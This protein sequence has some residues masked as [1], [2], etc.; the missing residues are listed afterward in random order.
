MSYSN[1]VSF[2]S[3]PNLVQPSVSFGIC[4]TIYTPILNSRF[5]NNTLVNI[6]QDRTLSVFLGIWLTR[7]NLISNSRFLNNTLVNINPD[8]TLSVFPGICLTRYN[9]LCILRYL[10][11][12]WYNSNLSCSLHENTLI[13]LIKRSIIP[14]N[15]YFESYNTG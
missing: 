9:S 7:Y 14:T 13:T 8:T 4:L 2:R 12:N 3:V 11:Y 6:N 1:I 15:E 5:L 10:S